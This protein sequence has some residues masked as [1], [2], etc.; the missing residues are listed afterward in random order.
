MFVCP[1]YM[2]ICIVLYI[3]IDIVEACVSHCIHPV[4][5][6]PHNYWD[7]YRRAAGAAEA[8][9]AKQRQC[10]CYANKTTRDWTDAFCACV[11]AIATRS[12]WRCSP[13]ARC[14]LVRSG[15]DGSGRRRR[16]R[17][18]RRRRRR[19]RACPHA[20]CQMRTFG[21][22]D[23]AIRHIGGRTHH[24]SA[25]SPPTARPPPPAISCERLARNCVVD[26]PLRATP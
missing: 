5:S 2:L 24:P 19:S 13:H 9:A 12:F 18:R 7:E 20:V 1:L 14:S 3:R 8:S 15:G 17:R 26:R 25:I 11:L 22:A 4:C 6:T 16:L 21:P 23:G 10:A